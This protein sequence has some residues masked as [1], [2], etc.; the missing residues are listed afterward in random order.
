M[1]ADE[2]LKRVYDRCPNFASHDYT[3][4]QLFDRC[5]DIRDMIERERPDIAQEEPWRQNEA[6]IDY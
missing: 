2:L 4:E 1:T 3:I 6:G 5:Q